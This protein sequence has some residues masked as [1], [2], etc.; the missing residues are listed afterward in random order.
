MIPTSIHKGVSPLGASAYVSPQRSGDFDANVTL[1]IE[2]DKMGLES[3]LLIMMR[4]IQ[5]GKLIKPKK[6]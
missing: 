2:N 6:V 5:L 4:A 3:A 1:G